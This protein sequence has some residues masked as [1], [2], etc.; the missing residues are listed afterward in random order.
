MAASSCWER[1]TS[2]QHLWKFREFLS[3]SLPLPTLGTLL[4]SSRPVPPRSQAAA[5][6]TTIPVKRGAVE[7][8]VRFSSDQLSDIMGDVETRIGQP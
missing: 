1:P 8:V 5:T 3:L 2:N 4:F 6:L 7:L